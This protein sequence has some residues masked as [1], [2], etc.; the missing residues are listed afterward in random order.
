M[1]FNNSRIINI[2]LFI[3]ILS[4]CTGIFWE[5]IIHYTHSGLILLP[6]IKYN[7]SIVCHTES[8]KRIG[9]EFA[10]TLTCAR[11]TGIY[12]GG[13]ISAAL[14]FIKPS[15]KISTKLFLIISFPMFLDVIL[16]SF[17]L[18]DYNKIIALVTGLLL[19]SSGF[20][21]IHESV[22]DLLTNKKVIN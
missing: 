7:Y 6:I 16:Y 9:Y 2:F 4:W 15:L 10:S 3:F 19:G 20:I 5:F 12:L 1:A 21:Y 11:C 22:I 18:Y 13:L 14:I 17:G 8:A